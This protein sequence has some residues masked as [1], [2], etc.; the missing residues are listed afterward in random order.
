MG[1]GVDVQ[2]ME[3]KLES[4]LDFGAICFGTA[5]PVTCSSLGLIPQGADG[6]VSLEGNSMGYGWNVGLLYEKGGTRVG[7]TY[8]SRVG[9]DLEGDADFT[10]TPALFTGLG[11]FTDTGIT[12]NFMTPEL[13]SIGFVQEVGEDWTLS[14]DMTRTGWDTFQELRI[15][16]DN[17]NQPDSVQPENWQDVYKASIGVDYDLNDQWTLRA[18]YGYDNS[19]V[20]DADRTARLPDGDRTWLSFGATWHYS[21]KW[22]FSA[23]Y[24]YLQLGAGDA[25]PF[26][27]VGATQDHV[28]GTYEGDASIFGLEM[29]MKF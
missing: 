2:Y 3:V 23:G 18:G 15:N 21:E 29:R 16:F 17:P 25:L 22:E 9:H 14:L 7:L 13:F 12:A 11:V 27:Q 26:D 20:S 19:P 5:G 24:A 28:I 6:N 1:F 8:R 10:G 4:A